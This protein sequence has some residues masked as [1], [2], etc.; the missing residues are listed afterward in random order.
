[1]ITIG[2]AQRDAIYDDVIHDLTGI[3]DIFICLENGDIDSANRLRRRFA[4]DLRLL[5]DLGWSATD[6]RE[7]FTLTMKPRRL[8]RVLGQLAAIRAARLVDVH[9]QTEEEAA[10]QDEL[11]AATN[12]GYDELLTRVGVSPGHRAN[13]RG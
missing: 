4:A 13:G 6:E 5:D 8:D 12:A 7:T 2:A 3:G 10:R 9:L 1:V 11:T